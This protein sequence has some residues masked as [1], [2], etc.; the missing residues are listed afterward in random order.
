MFRS[1]VEFAGG[2]AA[3][4]KSVVLRAIA[5]ARY[6]IVQARAKSA[7]LRSKRL[8][9][10]T[11]L[12]D[13]LAARGAT[14]QGFPLGADAVPTATNFKGKVDADISCATAGVPLFKKA[15]IFRGKSGATLAT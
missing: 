7:E 4:V 3:A 13:C 8:S 2:W 9:S 1:S 5:L 11:A 12:G 10:T 14:D 6:A 15:V